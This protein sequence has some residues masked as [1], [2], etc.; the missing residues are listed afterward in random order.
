MQTA[1]GTSVARLRLTF[2][3]VF[4]V[5]YATDIVTKIVAVDRLDGQPDVEV[6]GELLQLNL[7]RNPGAAFGTATGFTPVISVIAI[8][9]AVAVLWF[10]R[11]LGSTLWAVALGFLLAGVLGNLTDRMLRD[12]GP[13][14]GHVIDFLMLP[15]WPVFNIA[16]ICI[17]VA[18]GLIIVQ[19][20]RGVR[21]DGTREADHAERADDTGTTGTTETTGTTGTTGTAAVEGSEESTPATRSVAERPE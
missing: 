21:L 19:A 1:R 20:L 14:H 8:L 17:N 10:A 13:F 4:L 12:P 3:A 11:R 5:A 7:I 15:N 2:A 9:A 16:D 6:I 18:A